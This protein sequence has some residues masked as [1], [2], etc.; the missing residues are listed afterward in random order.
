MSL[1][2][3]GVQGGFDYVSDVLDPQDLASRDPVG[4]IISQFRFHHYIAETVHRQGGHG[5]LGHLLPGIKLVQGT[6]LHLASFGVQGIQGPERP[7]FG[8]QSGEEILGETERVRHHA[9]VLGTGTGDGAVAY[10]V[11]EVAGTCGTVGVCRYQREG[12]QA[13]GVLDGKLLCDV[14]AHGPSQ[15]VCLVDPE[16]VEECQSIIHEILTAYPVLVEHG[17]SGTPVIEYDD[18]VLLREL[19]YESLEE[20]GVPAESGNQY[21]RGSLP[22]F[23]VIHAY[24][25]Y[26]GKRHLLTYIR[27]FSLFT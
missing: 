1:E 21:D 14:S 13:F 9:D 16:V 10:T 2:R 4:Y 17:L 25:V 8:L 23:L 19:R 7:A 5:Y 3:L 12:S 6:H 11:H 24:P 26:V 22:R 18:P 15:H 27:P 20:S